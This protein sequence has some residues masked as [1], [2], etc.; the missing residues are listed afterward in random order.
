MGTN[1]SQ[2]ERAMGRAEQWACFDV[3]QVPARPGWLE[4]YR[5]DA[6]C[7]FSVLAPGLDAERRRAAR[8]AE[9]EARSIG[10]LLGLAIG[11]AL[12]AP[13]EFAP[14]RYGSTE[15]QALGHEVEV[16]HPGRFR[17]VATITPFDGRWNQRITA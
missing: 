7:D 16:I 10:A 4:L 5:P 6:L 12:G 2:G 15:L 11:D 13:L 3:A 8:P 9:D 14:V 1:Q 17:T